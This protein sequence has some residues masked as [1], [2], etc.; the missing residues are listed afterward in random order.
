[1]W[2][3]FAL[4]SAA[5]NSLSVIARKT[6]GSLAHPLELCWWTL[7]FGV[8]LG[9]GLLFTTHQPYYTDFGF[10]IPATISAL[11]GIASS[12]LAFYA[13][14]KGETSALAPLGNLLPVALLVTSFFILGTLPTVGGLL[15]IV[16]VVGGVYYSSLGKAKLS[17][18]FKQL[19]R[20]TGSRAMLGCVVL[21]SIGSSI[22]ALAL[23][24]ASPAFLL[25]YRQVISLVALSIILLLHPQR[26]RFRRGQRVMR[27][28]GWHIVAI[29]VFAT[30]AVYFQFQAI[31]L[32]DPVYVLTVKRIDVLFTILIAHFLFREKHV[33]R[34]FEGSLIALVG[35]VIICFAA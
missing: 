14:Q 4:L 29:S 7:L 13:Y 32:I 31:K 8:P 33:L 21:W 34:R 23:Q 5:L 2:F 1:M 15:G 20:S 28:W 25:A 12:S 27:R 9:I 26:H 10:I 16:L 22:D 18:P 17:H 30:L 6:H 19:W 3:Y 35:I 11:I 24:H